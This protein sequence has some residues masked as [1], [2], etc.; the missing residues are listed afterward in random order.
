MPDLEEPYR[1]IGVLDDG[2]A[3]LSETAR[4]HIRAA[5]LVIGAQRTLN[6]FTDQFQTQVECRDLSGKFMQIPGWITEAMKAGRKVVV[7]ATG[8]PLCHGIAG[9]LQSRL[10]ID[11]CEV[12]PNL[13]MVQ[14]ACARLGMPWQNLKVASVHGKDAGEWDSQAGPQQGMYAL[15]HQIIEHDQLA[16]YTSPDNTPGRIARMLVASGMDAQ[17]QIAV[18]EKLQQ[19]GERVLTQCSVAEVAKLEFAEPNIVLLWRDT[20]RVEKVRFG[21]DDQSFAQRKPEKGL[22]TKREVRAVSLA[23]MQL[24]RNS[25]IWDIGAGSG[26]VGIEAARLCPDG[27]VYA[28]E[29]NAADIDNA[30]QNQRDFAVH[31]YLLRH[32]KAPDGLDQ[33]PDPDAIF[34]G[35][36]GGNL[37]ELIRLCL[38]RLKPQGWLVMNFVTFENVSVAIETLKQLNADWDITQLQTSRSRPILHMHRLAAENPVWLVSAQTDTPHPDPLPQGEGE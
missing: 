12:L 31:N 14:L 27:Q 3:S 26:S 36:S 38:S 1:I 2:V 7:L 15:L 21:L 35:G 16:I 18:A 8:D 9:F 33:W 17:F 20:P 4:A 5:D 13:S 29:K 10:C 25:V 11:A 34:I 32:A 22:I 28:I 24:R 23:R 30:Q 37:A 19:P 6:L